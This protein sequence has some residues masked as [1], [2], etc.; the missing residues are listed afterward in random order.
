[1]EATYLSN[2]EQ[3]EKGIGLLLNAAC[4]RQEDALR[5]F[6]VRNAENSDR[7]NVFFLLLLIQNPFSRRELDNN[8]RRALEGETNG[9]G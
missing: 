6:R 9:L 2:L 1:M 3:I 5:A 8:L 7:I 4:K